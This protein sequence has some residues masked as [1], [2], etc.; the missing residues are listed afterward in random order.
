MNLQSTL[1]P[2][3]SAAASGNSLGFPVAG[4]AAARVHHGISFQDIWGIVLR[5][6]TLVIAAAALGLALALLLSLLVVPQYRASAT[7]EIDDEPVQ[8]VDLGGRNAIPVADGQFLETQLALLRSRSLSEKVSRDLKLADNPAFADQEAAPQARLDQATNAVASNVLVELVD[9]SRLVRVGYVSSDPGLAAD[10]ANNFASNFIQSTLQRRYDANN[11]ARDFLQRRIAE[12]RGRLEDSERQLVRYAQA[13]NI[14]SVGAEGGEGSE[15][16]ASQSLSA[17]SLGAANSELALAQNARVAAEQRYN[18]ATRSATTE[19]LQSPSL[20][21][22]KTQLSQ[23][24]S[25]YAQKGTELKPDHPEMAELQSGIDALTREIRGEQGTIVD[26]LR[27]EYRAAAAREQELR[28][29]VRALTG[30]VLDLRGRTIQYNILQ[31]D[32]DTNRQLYDALLQRFKEVGV[33]GGIGEN[34]I[35]IVDPAKRPDTPFEPNIPRNLLI[36]ALLGM[37]CGVAFAIGSGLLLNK[38]RLPADLKELLGISPLGALPL[39]KELPVEEALLTPRSAL[40]EAYASLRSQILFTAKQG[41]LRSILVTSSTPGEGKTTTSLALAQNFARMGRNTLLV[42]ADLRHP[43]FVVEAPTLGLAGVLTGETSLADAVVAT[44]FSNLSLLHA[45][46]SPANPADLLA[47][48]ELAKTV[49][50]LQSMYDIVIFDGP[51]VLGLVDAP[52]LASAVDRTMVV[53]RADGVRALAARNAMERL[54][55]AN[56]RILGGVLTMWEGAGMADAYGYTYSYGSDRTGK[57]SIR[58]AGSGSGSGGSAA[59]SGQPIAAKNGFKSSK[60]LSAGRRVDAV[61]HPRLHQFAKTVFWLAAAAALAL[62]LWPGGTDFGDWSDTTQHALAFAL[63]TGLAVLA[64][65]RAPLWAI[66]LALVILGAAIELIQMVPIVGRQA[67]FSEFVTDVAAIAF[68]MALVL[69]VRTG[70]ATSR[71]R[72]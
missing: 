27:S 69:V 61:R 29:R 9:D 57:A 44:E 65:P 13:Q 34:T 17:A 4:V 2:G 42:D 16:V 31:R 72:G 24:R 64:Y 26:A 18:E 47:N 70:F 71:R 3:E 10:V 30:N 40:F 58:I 6:R 54:R 22:M 14:V 55:A 33:S 66:A 28:G 36:G 35:A 48:G 50:L 23:L 63:L 45:G 11:Y 68:V 67:E 12:V 41:D 39:E 5:R 62:A 25:S 1:G 19:T 15:G 37:I 56:A 32:V 43:S 7:L 52:L 46:A 8:V 51:P 49:E 59:G 53:F 60:T 20:Q 38:I 21:S